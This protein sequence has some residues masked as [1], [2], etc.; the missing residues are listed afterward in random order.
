MARKR[1]VFGLVL[2]GV[3]A[4]VLLAS[5]LLFG[6]AQ[7]TEPTNVAE[8]TTGQQTPQD[9]GLEHV[10][11]YNINGPASREVIEAIKAGNVNRTIELTAAVRAEIQDAQ[12]ADTSGEP[13]KEATASA[14]AAGFT[15]NVI[16]NIRPWGDSSVSGTGSTSGGAQ[17]TSSTQDIRAAIELLLELQAAVQGQQSG[18]SAQGAEGGTGTASSGAQA[19]EGKIDAMLELL[20]GLLDRQ[21]EVGADAT[22]EDG[23]TDTT[24]AGG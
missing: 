8:Q 20:N 13:R 10:Y 1:K 9:N 17:S 5:V 15:Q 16:M 24:T 6:C 18:T 19:F 2:V 21:K 3:L 22:T 12:E 4:S 23:S 14:P 7:N 11:I